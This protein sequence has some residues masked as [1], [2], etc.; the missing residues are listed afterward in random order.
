MNQFPSK[1]TQPEDPSRLH[2][3]D[4]KLSPASLSGLAKPSEISRPASTSTGSPNIDPTKS[5]SD[6]LS[7]KATAAFIRRTLCAHHALSGPGGEKG[8]STPKPVDELLPP[9]T[10]SNEVDLQLYAII[11]VILKEFVYT[12]YAKIT[13]DHAFVDQVI[14]I[15]AH[16]TR[17]LEQ[18]LRKV[19]MESLLLDEI[20]QLMDAHLEAFRIAHKST[21]PQPLASSPREIYH[22]LTPHPALT[23]VPRDDDP[24]TVL[25]QQLNEEAWRQLLVQGVLAVL[26]PTEDLENACLRALIAE[27]FSEMILGNAVSQKVCE[28][29]FLWDAITT[30]IQASQP[31]T[32]TPETR[33][34]ETKPP[35]TTAANRLEQFGLL[36]AESQQD[37]VEGFNLN[38]RRSNA[39]STASGLFWVV[40]HYTFLASRAVWTFAHALATSSSLPPRSKTWLAAVNSYSP[41]QAERKEGASSISSA[42]LSD[43]QR[44]ILD[45]GIWPMISKVIALKVR[46]PWLSGMLALVHHGAVYGPGKVGDTDGAIDRSVGIQPISIA[47]RLFPSWLVNGSV[48]NP[49]DLHVAALAPQS[50]SVMLLSNGIAKYILNPS[51]I[52]KTLQIARAALFPNN[53]PGPARKI[54]DAA[55]IVL[56]RRR[57]AEAVANILPVAAGARF[58]GLTQVASGEAVDDD[59]TREAVVGEVEQVLGV[60]GDAYMNKHV[61]FGVLGLVVVRLA[62]ELGGKGV[63]ELMGE[64]VPDVEDY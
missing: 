61:I 3:S 39:A 55:E 36:S 38:R 26:L 8:R 59:N 57:C 2:P 46:M 51:Y 23:P 37:A 62:P 43:D 18:R 47:V 64:R 60:F 53:A 1:P 34:E 14:Q 10:S 17:A 4:A 29:W 63:G 15:I 27:I 50:L 56:I 54:P 45:M 48:H 6:F 52:P 31:R 42:A 12:W 58:F 20:P 41:Q 35:P 28:P 22:I 5:T 32:A 19:D 30:V 44:P 33:N 40:V 49:D 11:A 16:C 13:P 9:L 24:S 21:Y 25:E 7:D